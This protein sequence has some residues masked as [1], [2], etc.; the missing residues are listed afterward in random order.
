MILFRRKVLLEKWRPSSSSAPSRAILEI[1]FSGDVEQ[2]H[3]E[4]HSPP[5]YS[6]ITRV[7]LHP[8]T[9]GYE[10][11]VMTYEPVRFG[12]I[13]II[14]GSGNIIGKWFNSRKPAHLIAYLV[15]DN[16]RYLKQQWIMRGCLIDTVEC[17]GVDLVSFT[18]LPNH[19]ETFS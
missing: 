10:E 12:I 8:I 6:G 16:M 11:L 5:S 18:M 19:V 15:D 1:Q 7:G 4:L 17:F 3:V 14:H 2:V 9:E 13:D